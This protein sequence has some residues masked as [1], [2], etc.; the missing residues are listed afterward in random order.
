MLILN[1]HNRSLLSETTPLASS[2]SDT[3]RSEFRVTFSGEI[4]HQ[5]WRPIVPVLVDRSATSPK[6][7]L[8][9]PVT[10]T[11][12]TYALTIH[13][14]YVLTLSCHTPSGHYPQRS[15]QHPPAQCRARLTTLSQ[16]HTSLR[17]RTWHKTRGMA[18]CQR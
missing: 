11:A 15:H 17:Q 1:T 4:F 12:N 3:I 13:N 14:I 7:G 5:T 10:A 18:K 6:E 8:N 16:A 9:L 2:S